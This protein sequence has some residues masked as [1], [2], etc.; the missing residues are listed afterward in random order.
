MR[1]IV[2]RQGV[3][4]VDHLGQAVGGDVGVDL[5][6]GDVGVAEQGLDD[7]QVGAAFQQVGGEGVAQDVGAD[8]GRV[9]A[10]VDGGLVQQLGEAAR[11][12]VARLRR[13]RGTARGC[14]WRLFGQERRRGRPDRP[15]PP[16]RAASF[17]GRQPLLAALAA[18]D[19]IGRIAAHGRERAGPAVRRPAGP[20]RRPARP[21]RPGAGPRRRRGPRRRSAGAS[22]SSRLST[23]GRRRPCFGRVDPARGIVGP[24]ALAQDEAV[25]LAHGRRGGARPWPATGRARDRSANQASIAPRRR[26]SSGRRAPQRT[27]RRRPGRGA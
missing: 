26:R 14:P 19:Q 2:P 17:S 25:E 21:G 4:L 24:P 6:G 3:V 9:D 15:S 22:I 5:G 18:Y 13:A 1:R 11:G 16:S 8:A 7:A 20:R 27:P 23:L 12:Q 10:G